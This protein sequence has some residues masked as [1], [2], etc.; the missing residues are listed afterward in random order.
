M[1]INCGDCNTTNH[2]YKIV[3][4]NILTLKSRLNNNPFYLSENQNSF[5]LLSFLLNPYQQLR[6]TV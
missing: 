5:M 4:I 3:T 1:L 6:N 2:I